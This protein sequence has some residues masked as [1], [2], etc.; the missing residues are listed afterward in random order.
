MSANPPQEPSSIAESGLHIGFIGDLITKLLYYAGTLNGYQISSQL[1]L[2]YPTVVEPTLDFL[3]KEQLL[4]M[5][6]SGALGRVGFEYML[7]E[8][9][10]RWAREALERDQY[11]GP[12]PVP[13]R[14]YVDIVLK[15]SVSEL[16]VHPKDVAQAMQHLVVNPEMLDMIGPAVNSTRSLFLYG[17]PGNGKTSIAQAIARIVHRDTV[18]IPYAVMVD[19]HIMKLFDEFNHQVIEEDEQALEGRDRRWRHIRRPFVVAGGELT[20]A[21]LDLIYDPAIKYYEAPLQIKANNGVFLIDDFGRQQM[22]PQDLLNRWIVPLETRVDFLTLHTGKKIE[23]PFDAMIIFSTNIDPKELVDEAF[24]RRIRHKLYVGDPTPEQYREILERV[25]RE[26]GVE[27]RPDAFDHLMEL[28]RRDG[29]PLRAVHPRD[30][31]DH[32]LDIASYYGIP[33]VFSPETIERA[34]AAY[35]TEV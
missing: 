19:G 16:Y 30:L 14:D 21:D 35:F 29:R 17:P 2:P 26:K 32:V 12:A 9:G 6:G 31:V 7:T 22:R 27:L 15:Q 13:F 10:V 23:V 24:L 8:R 1:C 11:V 4:S 34:A 33:P 5:S 3:R 28:Y 18:F 20:M 25:C